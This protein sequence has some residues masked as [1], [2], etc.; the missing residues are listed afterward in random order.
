MNDFLK[1]LS[2]AA[3]AFADVITENI[4]PGQNAKIYTYTDFKTTIVNKRKKYP[5]IA[6]S[7][8]SVQVKNSF[9]NKVFPENKYIIRIVMLDS[10]EKP[11]HVNERNDEYVGSLV[12]ADSIDKK[13][14]DFMGDKTEKT[15]I[16]G[17]K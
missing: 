14:S 13:L 17:V 7:I 16:V 1:R 12:I 10:N 15:V 6:K 2:K 11:I 8:I 5:Q 4:V 9:D 3:D